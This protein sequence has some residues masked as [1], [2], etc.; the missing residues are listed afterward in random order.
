MWCLLPALWSA[1]LLAQDAFTLHSTAR[2][3][4][5]SAATTDRVVVKWRSQG[6]AA[7]QIESLAGR[8]Q[9]L[10]DWSGV[11]VRGVRSIGS[12]LDVLGLPTALD[13]ASMRTTLAR[14]RSDPA[15]EYAEADE[16][17]YILALPTDPRYAAGSDSVGDWQGQWYLG[18]SSST[19]PAAIDAVTAW[20]TTRGNGIIVAVIDTGVDLNHPDLA[21]KLLTG[22]DFVCHDNSNLGCTAAGATL[23]LTANDGNGW[24]SD[25]SDPGDWISAS[26]LARTDNF[27]DGCGD[28]D[29]HDEPIPSSW[30]GTRVAGVIAAATDNGVGIAGA[31][32]DVRIVPV[33]V[34]GKCSGYMSDLVAGMYWAG[35]VSDASYAGL[36]A[37][38]AQRAHILNISLGGRSACSQTEQDAVNQLSANG[39]LVV[40]AAGNDG[41]PVGAPANCSG[42]L[43]VA[44]LRHLG[45]K[46]GYSNV[47]S[48]DAALSIAAPA[49]N[50][51]NVLASEPCLYSIET[52][53]NEGSE[54]PTQSFYTYALFNSGYTGNKL[55]A[56][57]VG[58]SFSAPLAS[59]VAALMV[60]VNGELTSTEV[61]DR[62]KSSALPFPTPA[63]TPSGGVCHVASTNKN[64]QGEYTDVQ[65]R[66]CQCTTDTCGAGMLNAPAALNAALRP[67][68]IFTSSKAVAS[69]GDRIELDGRDS[70]AA[71]GHYIASYHWSTSPDITVANA[72][73]PQAEIVFPAFRP[74]TVYLTVTDDAGRSDT[75]SLKIESS[76]S[77]DDE[78]GGGGSMG[79]AALALAL[80][81]LARCIRGL[82]QPHRN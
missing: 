45:T 17:R 22:H 50:C 72:D 4:P 44:G 69:I 19:T 82:R 32:P 53:S 14:L 18:P 29:N 36:V 64:A 21:G 62:I 59:A 25:P 73:S 55:N 24:D 48:T 65:D 28:G 34:I 68:S 16:R 46:V 81:W 30:H 31:A 8:A 74:I 51:V 60:S 49:G 3:A 42:V 20:D 10:R 67:V 7:V 54:G 75:A 37:T 33:R 71:N 43:S 57:N 52:L 47:S 9:R 76:F 80:L 66:D 35:G 78:E 1:S 63:T 40:A 12:R 61:I 58:T 11:P 41:G 2:R 70:L 27:F 15:I 26:D 56:A 5:A 6:V 79:L 38:I 77:A 39:V 23:F 13:D